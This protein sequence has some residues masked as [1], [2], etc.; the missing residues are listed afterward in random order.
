MQIFFYSNVS[1]FFYRQQT[2]ECPVDRE[3]L[4]REKVIYIP[5][6]VK[7]FVEEK[8]GIYLPHRH[9]LSSRMSEYSRI[10]ITFQTFLINKPAGSDA[11]FVLITR[12]HF[13]V[14][15]RR[16]RKAKSRKDTKSHEICNPIQNFKERSK[17]WSFFPF[18][19][20]RKTYK[21]F[22]HFTFKLT[23]LSRRTVACQNAKQSIIQPCLSG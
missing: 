15:L 5:F 13:Q 11:I 12:D 21:L 16:P 4:D 10:R 22:N 17:N 9:S 20:K 6:F 2:P 3:P 1:L 18:A 19:L 14:T 23:I 7:R 8:E